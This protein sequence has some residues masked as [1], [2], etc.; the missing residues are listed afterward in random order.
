MSDASH[1]FDNAKRRRPG[2]HDRQRMLTP[3]Y[4]LEPIRQLL[5][6]IDL[7][8]CTESDNPTRARRFYALWKQAGKEK[9][10]V[11]EY[12]QSSFGITDDRQMPASGYEAACLW[13]SSQDAF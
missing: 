10:H 1:R 3:D 5:C 9:E 8:P 12:L 4:V 11:R 7:D 6:G 13:A 2:D